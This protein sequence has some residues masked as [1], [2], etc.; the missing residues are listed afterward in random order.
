MVLFFIAH[1]YNCDSE[2]KKHAQ[3]DIWISATDVF[4]NSLIAEGVAHFEGIQSL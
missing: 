4:F 1:R 2:V 3:K